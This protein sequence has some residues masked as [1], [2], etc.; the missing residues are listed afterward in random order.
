VL[1][2]DSFEVEESKASEL[3]MSHFQRQARTLDYVAQPKDNTLG[4]LLVEAY[5]LLELRFQD[6]DVDGAEILTFNQLSAR[7]SMV[8][9]LVSMMM[10]AYALKLSQFFSLF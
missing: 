5:K 10:I 6:Y 8:T 9:L 3:V 4:A 1:G 2:G 7:L